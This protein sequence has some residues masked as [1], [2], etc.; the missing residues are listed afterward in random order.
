MQAQLLARPAI[1][2]ASARTGRRTFRGSDESKV[3]AEPKRGKRVGR[4]GN[5]P[6]RFS[7]ASEQVC[8]TLR[9]WARDGV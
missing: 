5:D 7:R 3:V 4:R 8:M 2:N 9:Q 6:S 1:K